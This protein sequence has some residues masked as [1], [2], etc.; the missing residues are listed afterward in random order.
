MIPTGRAFYKMSGSGNDFVIIDAMTSPA[1]ELMRPDA[2]EAICARAT[3]VG[4][5]GL[6]LLEPSSRADYRMTYLNS[7][8]SRADL[9]GN[10]SLCSAR[11]ASEL[12][13]LTAADFHIETDAGI[14]SARLLEDGPEIDLQPVTDVR[15]NLPFRLASGELSIGFALAGVPHLVVRVE[16]VAA[17]DV[18]DRGRPLRHDPSLEHGANVNFV[19]LDP[20]GAWW[21]RTYERGVEGETLACGTG[22]VATAIMLAESGETSDAVSLVTRSGRA[23]R[24]RLAKSTSGWQPSLAGEARIVFRGTLGEL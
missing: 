9:C 16:D 10:A 18:R 5:D 24:V 8:G 12:G 21:I 11:L 17:V 23:L 6:V 2:V 3:G 13:L 1:H 7:D 19:S 20:A 4:A 22:A 15:A 14:L